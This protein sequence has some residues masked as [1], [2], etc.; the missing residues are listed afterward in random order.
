MK[1]KLQKILKDT[2]TRD[3][4]TF[5]YQNQASIDS[6]SGISAWV[7]YDREEVQTALDELVR[8]DVLKKDSTGSAKGYSYT[9][10]AKI[11][12]IVNELMSDA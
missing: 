4:L 9:R 10:D 11:M 3:I 12:K 8:F 5:F 7:H 1:D 6:A 2:L